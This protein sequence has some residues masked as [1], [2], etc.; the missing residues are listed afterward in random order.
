[1]KCV[2]WI[3]NGDM[4]ASAA[5]DKTAKLLNFK[6]GK[7]IYTGTTSDG[8]KLLHFNIQQLLDRAVFVCFI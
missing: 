8:S 7:I 1:M 3:P 4:L 5:D 2:R 6:T